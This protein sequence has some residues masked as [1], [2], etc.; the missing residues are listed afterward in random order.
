MAGLRFPLGAAPSAGGTGEEGSVQSIHRTQAYQ[1]TSLP[2]LDM[3]SGREVDGFIIPRW[4]TET[5]KVQLHTT[6]THLPSDVFSL[7]LSDG[8][9]LESMGLTLS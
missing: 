5:Q 8:P 3:I 7:S 9:T 2:S 6:S 4:E 1:V